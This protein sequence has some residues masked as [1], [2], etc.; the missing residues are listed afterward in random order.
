M[1]WAAADLAAADANRGNVPWLVVTS[2]YPLY[3]AMM[4]DEEAEA[5]AA[6]YT[7]DLAEQE[8][9]GDGTPWSAT[10]TSVLWRATARRCLRSAGSQNSPWLSY[11]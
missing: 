1:A 7:S 3:T 5:S 8:R 6:W 2:H 9:G 11:L 4:G 10:P